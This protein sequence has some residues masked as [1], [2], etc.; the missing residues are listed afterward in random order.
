MVIIQEGEKI[1]V[2]EVERSNPSV[3]YRYTEQT[4]DF[5]E[6]LTFITFVP[7]EPDPSVFDVPAAIC[8]Q[9]KFHQYLYRY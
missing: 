5:E 3:L 6:Q 4:N 7:E 9:H 2:V 8:G 1:R